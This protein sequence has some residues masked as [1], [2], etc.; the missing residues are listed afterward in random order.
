MKKTRIIAMGLCAVLLTGCSFTN[1]FA[2]DE[3]DTGLSVENVGD[4][5]DNAGDVSS[6]GTSEFDY[7]EDIVDIVSSALPVYKNVYRYDYRYSEDDNYVNLT[8]MTHSWVLL[9]EADKG[10][11]PGLYD[12][13]MDRAQEGIKNFG[14]YSNT[15][16]SDATEQYQSMAESGDEASFPAYVDNQYDYISRA[17]SKIVSICSSYETYS[18]GAHGYYATYGDSYLVETG[19]KIALSNVFTISEDEFASKLKDKL[20]V[21]FNE[22]GSSS[23]YVDEYLSHYKFEP[24]S[25]KD[26]SSGAEDWE[27][28]YIF[29]FDYQGVH[30]VFNPYDIADYASGAFDVV[31]GYDEGVI[32]DEYKLVPDQGYINH[33][34]IPV[35]GK[36]YEYKNEIEGMRFELAYE[37]EEHTYASSITL[38]NG[39]K[40]ASV[41]A[42]IY[43]EDYYGDCYHIYTKDGREYIYIIF[44]EFNDFTSLVAFDITGGDVKLCG[45]DWFH[46][47]YI[48]YQD[49]DF[50]GEPCLTDPDNMLLGHVGEALG[51]FQ[52]YNLYSVGADG[53]PVENDDVCDFG[54]VATDKI[55]A[56]K[57]VPAVK[58]V[59]GKA[60]SESSPIAPGTTVVPV[61]T[62]GKSYVDVQLEDGSV[63]R[64]T[65]TSYEYPAA[66]DGTSVDEY[67]DELMYVG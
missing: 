43:A 15:M 27:T 46:D 20:S 41:D 29:Y 40:E 7:T 58:V 47:I 34:V 45:S 5:A 25:S 53:M 22:R 57:E 1:P 8:Q 12:A 28:E 49:Q 3:A 23:D 26:V 59:D 62:D 55:V 6:E 10:A 63:V 2:K 67:F 24:D 48:D 4:N 44:S 61:A 38:V 36:D 50:S 30:I 56:K 35:C 9:R 33:E 42:D 51:S 17:D 16:Y 64:I 54:M 14:D 65:Y 11:Y 52:Y 37:D 66:I 39:D 21:E 19:E 31:F 32:A 13:L 18:G 60:T